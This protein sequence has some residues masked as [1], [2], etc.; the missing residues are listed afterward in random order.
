MHG[1]PDSNTALTPSFRCWFGH[2][3]R[4]Q[5]VRMWPLQKL[6]RS[7]TLGKDLWVSGLSPVATMLLCCTT[8][9]LFE[10]HLISRRLRQQLDDILT[11]SLM[12]SVAI[13][14]CNMRL[15][16]L[17][18]ALVWHNPH[19]WICSITSLHVRVQCE[20]SPGC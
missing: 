19:I 18:L 16:V 17:G 12:Y 13:A 2:S 9:D 1:I 10:N 11:T 8:C 4:S 5:D 20:C 7:C 3:P 14:Y 15:R 6:K